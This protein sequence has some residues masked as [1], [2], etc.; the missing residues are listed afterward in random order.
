MQS[1]ILFDA[2]AVPFNY[3]RAA[4]F[5][6]FAAAMLT[7]LVIAWC[8]N[9]YNF[10]RS[11]KHLTAVAVA[12]FMLVLPF[13]SWFKHRA[14]QNA[15]ADGADAVLI[16]GIIGDHWVREMPI[17]S[18]DKIEMQT[19]EHFRV[20]NVIFEFSQTESLEPYFTNA[21]VQS[22][23]IYDGMRVRIA[24]TE[25]SGAKAKRRIVRLEKLTS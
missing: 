5:F 8:R 25:S 1:E 24:F 9:T 21:R 19:V 6:A 18:G 13:V 12:L 3:L 2:A 23:K 17:E 11:F 16:E 10:Y 15:A 7:W 14:L 4:A 20:G 22:T